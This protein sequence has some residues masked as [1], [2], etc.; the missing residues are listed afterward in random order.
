MQAN[1]AVAGVTGAGQAEPGDGRTGTTTACTRV[2]TATHVA[3]CVYWT[4]DR[5]QCA[6]ASHGPRERPA[7]EEPEKTD[8][9]PYGRIAI[10]KRVPL[11]RVCVDL[12][13]TPLILTTRTPQK[14]ITVH[15]IFGLK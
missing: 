7:D 14:D 11:P 4:L 5:D 12:L 1:E 13:H 15:L 10:C 2:F 8:R 9:T 6:P 3:Q